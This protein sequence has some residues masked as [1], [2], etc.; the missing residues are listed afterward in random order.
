MS[1]FIKIYAVQIQLFLSLV[2]K[3]LS[4]DHVMLLL[5][6]VMTKMPGQV[7]YQDQTDQDQSC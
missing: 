3:E 5:A 1:H 6:A 7:V 4:Y 2:L